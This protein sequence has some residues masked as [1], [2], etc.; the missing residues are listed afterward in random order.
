VFY[1]R[2]D[3]AGKRSVCRDCRMDLLPAGAGAT[4]PL[5][6]VPSDEDI[7]KITGA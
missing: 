6:G 1:V 5:K 4:V 7:R 2:L 3:S